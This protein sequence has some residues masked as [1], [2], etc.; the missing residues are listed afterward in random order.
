MDDKTLKSTEGLSVSSAYLQRDRHRGRPGACDEQTSPPRGTVAA[1]GMRGCRAAAIRTAL[2][3]S[4]TEIN[5]DQMGPFSTTQGCAPPAKA[6]IWA[7]KDCGSLRCH[8]VAAHRTGAGD[9]RT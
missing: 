5:P 8:W 2:P 7:Q 3:P 1:P 4:L 6:A 9:C